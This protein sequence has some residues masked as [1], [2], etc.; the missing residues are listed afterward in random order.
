MK[1]QIT[2]PTALALGN[3]DG[4]HR[5]HALVLQ[6]AKQMAQQVGL[7]PGV[8]LFDEHP[9]QVLC[10]K[11]PPLLMTGEEKKA[12]LETAGFRVLTLSF[13][14]VK[15]L[16]PEAGGDQKIIGQDKGYIWNIRQII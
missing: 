11:A 8:L 12:R 9:K 16:P 13:G 10:G 1:Q 2:A 4:L 6:G 3:F 5:G 7:V 14:S 15:D